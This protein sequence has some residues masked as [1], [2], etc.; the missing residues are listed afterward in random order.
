[1]GHRQLALWPRSTLNDAIE[2][3]LD[4]LRYHG[5]SYRH[6]SISYSGGKD[7]TALVTFVLWA[8]QT[9]QVE[10]PNSLTVLY[11][12]TR[13]EFPILQETA[14]SVL[15]KVRQAG[16]Q[17][18]VTVPEMDH[19]FFVYMLGWGVTPP[20]QRFRWCT[21]KLK[22]AP[23]QKALQATREQ[24]GEKLLILTGVRMG[25][26]AARDQT[27]A[28]SCSRDSGECGQGWLQVKTPES[29]GDT[30][31]PLLHW[32]LCH[33]YDWIFFDDRCLENAR[34]IAV[35]YGGDEVRTGCMCCNLVN[36]DRALD[37]I[38]THP[39]Y[40]Q[41]K[42]LYELQHIYAEMKKPQYRLQK[43]GGD[44]NKDGQFR[45]KPQRMGPLTFE[46]RR[47]FFGRIKAVECA[48]GVNLINDQE[49]RYIG[50]LW[51][52]HALPEKW[53]L[54]DTVATAPKPKR[55][56]TSDR[57]MIETPLLV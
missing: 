3:S 55:H 44:R 34:N 8:I 52:N 10:P 57:R 47:Y 20:T 27:I 50:W 51:A 11:A 18:Q 45:M 48:A 56:V 32:R 46:A 26:S 17:T 28:I 23:M 36:E 22:I 53:T 4:N 35:I 16:F 33:I 54:D 9:R 38:V 30:L 1:M 41:L 21:E 29:V 37:K 25:E 43:V 24:A 42:V 5:H 40:K 14:M 12:D 2:Q 39:E 13:M 49:A 31:A 15:E 7:S 6:W 19:R